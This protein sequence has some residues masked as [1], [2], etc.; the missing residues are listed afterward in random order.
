MSRAKHRLEELPSILCMSGINEQYI[1]IN[2]NKI[3]QKKLKKCQLSLLILSKFFDFSLMKKGHL[4]NK[5]K[6]PFFN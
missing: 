2:P 3:K 4:F 5:N 1:I 6:Q